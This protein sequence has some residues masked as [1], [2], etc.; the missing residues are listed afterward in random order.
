MG[1]AELKVEQLSV[2]RRECG[3]VEVRQF[4][5]GLTRLCGKVKKYLKI[6]N[7]R[8]FYHLSLK[9]YTLKCY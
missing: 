3:E 9:Q 7:K 8:V 6:K 1:G 4:P 5:F 2:S